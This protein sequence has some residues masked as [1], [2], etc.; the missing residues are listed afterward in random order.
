MTIT[1]NTPTSDTDGTATNPG[2]AELLAD[3]GDDVLAHFRRRAAESDRDNTYFHE[4]LAVLRSVGYLA[5][6]VPAELGGGGRT[7]SEVAAAQRRIARFAPATALATSMH[8][9][10]VGLAAEM[11]R[12]G[13][14]SC[15][16]ILESAVE[17]AIFA[18]GHAERGNDAPVI[19]ST[20]I[21]VPV[22]GGYRV[23]GH[24]MFGSNGPA[25]DYLGIHALDASDPTD[26]QII[27]G[28]VHRDSEGV[29]VLPNWDTLGMRASQSYDTVMESVFIP[30]DK[31]ARTI[32]AGSD[33]D[34]FLLA[35]NVWALGLIAHVYLGTADRAL[36]L[37][38][39]DA[40][41]KSS[42]A[43]PGITYAYNP[44]IQHRIAEMGLILDAGAATAERL[45]ADWDRGVDH[46]AAW[47]VRIPAAK[48]N[49]VEAAKR[50]VDIALDVSGGAAM[51]R[52]HELER[53]Y[54][55][56]RCGGFHPANDALTHETI[57][58]AL[59]GIDPTRPRW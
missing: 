10:W 36:E 2:Y 31:I 19:M 49:A 59:L 53:L 42:V 4:D 55:D 20:S 18:A 28:F 58:K 52:G 24:K 5:A 16:W 13:D 51:F 41:R 23:D 12:F 34:L 3:L 32:P 14:T 44:M 6:A 1:D 33:A 38:V 56:V 21:A 39:E 35:M 25:W 17:G 40:N 9:Y 45:V 11:E 47:G 29:S 30:T 8:H 50:V 27:H 37:A 7:L 43:I 46:G 48:W 15:R 26:P 54:R 22:E 57:G